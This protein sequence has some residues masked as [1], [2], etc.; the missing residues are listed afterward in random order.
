VQ[1]FFA[2]LA[3][4]LALQLLCEIALERRSRPHDSPK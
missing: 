2:L 4:F 1:M 3:Q